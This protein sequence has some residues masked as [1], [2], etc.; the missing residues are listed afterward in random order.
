MCQLQGEEGQRHTEAESLSWVPEQAVQLPAGGPASLKLAV[1]R[2]RAVPPLT[3]SS[4]YSAS[5]T[6]LPS[7][8]VMPKALPAGDLLQ[9]PGRAPLPAQPRPPGVIVSN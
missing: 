3:M 5:S 8:V 1:R 2:D 9:S 6:F 4:V 7:A